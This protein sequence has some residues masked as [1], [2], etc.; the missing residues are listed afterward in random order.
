MYTMI[1]I[2]PTEAFKQMRVRWLRAYTCTRPL[3]GHTQ[4]KINPSLGISV[5]PNS[6]RFFGRLFVV[7]MVIMSVGT[8]RTG[9][10]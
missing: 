2:A 1:F 6:S 9:Y 5:M 10:R 7:V 3:F 4:S 8:V